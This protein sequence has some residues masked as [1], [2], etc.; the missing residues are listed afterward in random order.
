MCLHHE[1]SSFT[2]L[3]DVTPQAGRAARAFV[4]FILLLLLLETYVSITSSAINTNQDCVVVNRFKI[5]EATAAFVSVFQDL[6]VFYAA[7]E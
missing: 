1:P 6:D 4:L 3:R 7:T 5:D 2:H